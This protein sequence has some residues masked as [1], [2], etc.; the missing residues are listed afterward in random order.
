MNTTQKS[1]AK[2]QQ[3]TESVIIGKPHVI[4]LAII[5]LLARGHL[6][7]E[8]VVPGDGMLFPNWHPLLKR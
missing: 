8:D 3:S 5:A 4:Q 1:I 7:I 2:L 6:L